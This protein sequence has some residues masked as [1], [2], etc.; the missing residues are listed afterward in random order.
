MD[1]WDGTSSRRS[2]GSQRAPDRVDYDKTIEQIRLAQNGFNAVDAVTLQSVGAQETISGL[3]I[4]EYGDG[5]MHK[6]VFTFTA[7]SLATLDGVTPATDGAWGTD[8]LYTFPTGSK[9]L[10]ASGFD[11]N[12]ANVAGDD[13][14]TDTADFDIGLGSV[15]V[16]AAT[17]F[18]LTGTLSDYGDATVALSGGASTG[19]AATVST[20]AVHTATGLHLNLR[21]VDNAD[22]GVAA[23]AVLLT[24]SG[25]IVWSML[26]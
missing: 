10:Q 21:T 6:T 26:K 4:T 5:A 16:A 14:L 15:A 9:L 3:A 19:D 18:S 2:A 22:H 24:G 8:Q 25:F 20:P 1:L 23:G 11:L 12:L 17:A 7:F 13:G